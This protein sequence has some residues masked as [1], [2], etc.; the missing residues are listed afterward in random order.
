MSYVNESVSSTA[1][2]QTGASMKFWG[3][4]LAII[5]TIGFFGYFGQFAYEDHKRFCLKASPTITEIVAKMFAGEEE[6][7]IKE[8]V[9]TKGFKEEQTTYFQQ[10]I[11]D[12]FEEYSLI[13]FGKADKQSVQDLM[14]SKFDNC[15][16]YFSFFVTGSWVPE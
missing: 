9:V 6:Q 16:S 3:S 12:G 7:A 10:V 8:F 2:L 1:A 5:L 13:A 11:T 4:I 15:D 14:L